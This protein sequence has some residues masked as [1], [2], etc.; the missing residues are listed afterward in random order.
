[1]FLTQ[2]LDSNVEFMIKHDLHI[3]CPDMWNSLFSCD[4]VSDDA[5]LFM[6]SLL[7]SYNHKRTCN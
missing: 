7:I 3:H 4:F 1:M 6:V 2:D 5:F